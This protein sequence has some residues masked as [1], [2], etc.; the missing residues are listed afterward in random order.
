MIHY[1]LCNID[2]K[3]TVMADTETLYHFDYKL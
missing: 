2:V 3:M 1:R